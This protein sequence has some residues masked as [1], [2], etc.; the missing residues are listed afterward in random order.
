[1][2]CRP[3][4]GL[5]IGVT[6]TV[7][8]PCGGCEPPATANK[9]ADRQIEAFTGTR[10]AQFAPQYQGGSETIDG[11]GNA[12]PTA[13]DQT[14]RADRPPAPG[15]VR[16]PAA[17]T[18]TGKGQYG[19]DLITTPVSTYFA[20]KDQVVFQYQLPKA[21]EL[22]EAAY[23]RKP[24]NYEEFQREIVM[25]NGIQLPELPPTHRYL[26]DPD[27]GKLLIEHPDSK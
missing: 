11:V 1:M 26:Y 13:N 22:Y 12:S 19:G 23:Q 7:L 8:M 2:R 3:G 20:V 16:E 24:K 27:T 5:K 18:L 10:P 6:L 14:A 4:A 9:P 25:K 21:M 15:A 17:A